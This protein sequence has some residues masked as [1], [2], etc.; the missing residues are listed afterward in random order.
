MRRFKRPH[1]PSVVDFWELLEYSEWRECHKCSSRDRNLSGSTGKS[2]CWVFISV[3]LLLEDWFKENLPC[4]QLGYSTF[5]LTGAWW[6]HYFP[7]IIFY[8]IHDRM[9]TCLNWLQNHKY[10]NPSY[11]Q[12]IEII[13]SWELTYMFGDL[14]IDFSSSNLNSIAIHRNGLQQTVLIL[15]QMAILYTQVQRTRDLEKNSRWS[16]NTHEFKEQEIQKRSEPLCVSISKYQTMKQ[17]QGP[18][19]VFTSHG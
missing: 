15:Q 13:K 11:L 17:S 7:L 14:V 1:C 8:S 5:S 9:T 19:D 4:L 10:L 3:G 2:G 18:N 16:S 6:G 12:C